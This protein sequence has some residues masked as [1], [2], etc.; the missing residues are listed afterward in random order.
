[1]FLACNVKLLCTVRRLAAVGSAHAVTRG[2]CYALGSRGQ[3]PACAAELDVLRAAVGDSR[4]RH[5]PRRL[6]P[7]PRL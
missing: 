3:R 4:A 2:S 1:M 6:L 5:P 7:L